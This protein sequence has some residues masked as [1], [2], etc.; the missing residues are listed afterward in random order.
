MHTDPSSV[1]K[2]PQDDD[3]ADDS[4]YDRGG[5]RGMSLALAFMC[6][7]TVTQVFQVSSCHC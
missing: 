5:M 1:C 3:S 4:G 2:P 7:L 6:M